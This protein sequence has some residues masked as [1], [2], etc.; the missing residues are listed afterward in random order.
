[1]RYLNSLGITLPEL[2]QELPKY[3]LFRTDV[4]I[5]LIICFVI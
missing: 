3:K 2:S 4:I 5:N 1:M